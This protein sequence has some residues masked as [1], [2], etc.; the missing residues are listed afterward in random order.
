MQMADIIIFVTV[1]SLMNVVHQM[2][3]FIKIQIL[4]ILDLLYRG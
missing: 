2:I 3:Y 1:F 4:F